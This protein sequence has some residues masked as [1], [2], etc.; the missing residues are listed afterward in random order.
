MNPPVFSHS[1]HAPWI[2]VPQVL[3][4]ND[5]A[6]DVRALPLLQLHRGIEVV[7]FPHKRL[8][9]SHAHH[10]DHIRSQLPFIYLGTDMLLA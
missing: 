8:E 2:V 10:D 4:R 3:L 7:P 9:D 5:D 6:A 1:P